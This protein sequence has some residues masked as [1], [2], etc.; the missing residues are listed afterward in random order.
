MSY[1]GQVT[2]EDTRLLTAAFCA[3]LLERALDEEVN[4]VNAEMLLRER[5]IELTEESRS[6]SGVFSSSI[7]AELECGSVTYRV[8]GTLF[9]N[10]MPRLIRLGDYRL[11]AYLDGNLL[12]FTH[13]D[14]PGIIGAVG[15]TFGRNNVNIAQM[16]VGRTGDAPGGGAIGVLNLDDI[17]SQE[18]MQE[19]L[20]HP[21]IHSVKLI[22][23]PPAGRLPSWFPG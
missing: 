2:D 8:G 12:I 13:H 18:A 15:T 7:N 17:P 21:A 14:V 22:Q 5:G 23:L 16:A 4:I 1:R 6:D 11:E 3:G 20:Q 19:V 10:N 9:G